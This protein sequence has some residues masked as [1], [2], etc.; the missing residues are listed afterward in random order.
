M[1]RSTR[2]RWANVASGPTCAPVASG[3]SSFR[4][5]ARSATRASTR[6][7]T[8]RSTNRRE[9]ATHDCPVPSKMPS[10]TDAT[11]ASMSASANTMWGDLP[12]SSRATGISFSAA[13][14]AMRRPLPVPPVNDT[15]FTPGCRT[16]A[17]PATAPV[18]GRMLRSPAGSPASSAASPRAI[19]PE[20]VTSDGFR[21]TALPAARAGATFCASIVRG[22]FTA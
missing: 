16:S 5:R 1:N 9:P 2:S 21:I 14:A 12:P 7:W 6:S 20:G 10:A 19:A 17:S 8:L 18:P 4:R 11:A 13:M 15:H 3:R 22:E